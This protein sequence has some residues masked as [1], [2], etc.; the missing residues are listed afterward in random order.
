M[1]VEPSTSTQNQGDKQPQDQNQVY[2][3]P[4]N[5]LDD[6]VGDIQHQSQVPY[7]RVHQCI[8][9]DHPVDNILGDIQK[10]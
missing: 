6:E 8:Q 10:G 3:D 9:R 2:E 1:Q 5:F 7:P 4:N